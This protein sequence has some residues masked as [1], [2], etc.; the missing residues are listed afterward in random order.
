MKVSCQEVFGP[1][2][3]VSPYV[4][5]ED[6]LAGINDPPY[7]LQAGAFTQGIK[8]AFQSFPDLDVGTV[9]INE[10]P[11]FRADHIPYGGGKHSGLSR[12]GLR[13]AMHER[14]DIKLPRL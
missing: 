12:V 13:Y 1:V 5:F 8:K 3:T 6:A 4:K 10:I 9:L 14:T 7:G 11:T 2:V